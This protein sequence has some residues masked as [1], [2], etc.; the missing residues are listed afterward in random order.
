MTETLY[1]FATVAGTAIAIPTHEL[2]A[3][4][5]LGEIV[6]VARSAP[7]LRGLAALRSRVLTVIDARAVVTGEV[8]AM[9][10]APL[11]II[12]GV[13]GHSYGL[14]IDEVSDIS[15]AENAILP[16]SGRVDEAWRPFAQGMVQYQDRLHLAVSI[17]AMIR[18]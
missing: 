5:R 8:A 15:A 18:Q 1:L 17:A 4:A 16:V 6:P 11:A 2:E 3:V 10:A 9:D 13:D 12:A 14:L 7:H